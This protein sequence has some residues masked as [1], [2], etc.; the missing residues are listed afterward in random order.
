MLPASFKLISLSFGLSALIG[1]SAC[2][3]PDTLD[4]SPEKSQ[5][6]ISATHPSQA[7]IASAH[8]LATQ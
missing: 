4:R 2:S 8:P 1:L 3:Q 5:L 6:K 7:A